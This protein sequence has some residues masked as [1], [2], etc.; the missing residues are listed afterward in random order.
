MW[1]SFKDMKVMN[2]VYCS[3]EYSNSELKGTNSC[4]KTWLISLRKRPPTTCSI[5]TKTNMIAMEFNNWASGPFVLIANTKWLETLLIEQW[6]SIIHVIVL[7]KCSGSATTCHNEGYPDPNN[8]DQCKCPKGLDN[9]GC[10]KIIDNVGGKGCNSP[11]LQTVLKELT[12]MMFKGWS[13]VGLV[14]VDN[15]WPGFDKCQG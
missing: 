9:P 12:S 4:P 5:W 10:T 13:S 11:L 8:C 3:G 15:Y 1:L 14:N 2:M 7:D 6:W